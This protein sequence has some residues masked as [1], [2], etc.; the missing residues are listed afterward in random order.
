MREANFTLR[1]DNAL[2]T[3]F[4]EAARRQDRT[5]AQ[6]IRDYRKPV[7]R[8]STSHGSGPEWKPLGRM[9]ARVVR[10]PMN[11][12]WRDRR[13]AVAACW[14]RPDVRRDDTAVVSPLGE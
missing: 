9:F 8:M 11:R 14:L 13:N 4:A 10:L 5:A 2:K 3:A 6:L 1:V 12:S 7:S